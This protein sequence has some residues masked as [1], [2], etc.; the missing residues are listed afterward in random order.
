MKNIKYNGFTN[1]G[2]STVFSDSTV[3]KTE[4]TLPSPSSLGFYFDIVIR[5][6]SISPALT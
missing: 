1:L 2:N 5:K 6:R 3:I 4:I